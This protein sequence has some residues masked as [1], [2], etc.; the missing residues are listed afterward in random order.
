MYRMNSVLKT[1]LHG[2]ALTHDGGRLFHALMGGL[3]LAWTIGALIATGAFC[4]NGIAAVQQPAAQATNVVCEDREDVAPGAL[5]RCVVD[6]KATA[7][8]DI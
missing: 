6:V 4:V 8:H 1:R 3:V 2:F 5:L 7:A